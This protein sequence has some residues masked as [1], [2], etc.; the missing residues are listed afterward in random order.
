MRLLFS[1]L[2]LIFIPFNA[3]ALSGFCPKDSAVQIISRQFASIENVFPIRIGGVKIAGGVSLQRD[4]RIPYPPPSPVC[5]CWRTIAGIPVPLPGIIIGYYAPLATMEIVKMPGCFPTFSL[6]LPLPGNVGGDGSD[7]DAAS[8][9]YFEAHYIKFNVLELLNIFA[10][11]A[12]TFSPSSS[13]ID[14]GWITEYDPSWHDESISAFLTPETLLFANPVAQI[15]CSADSAANVIGYDIDV[16]YWCSGGASV[17][18]LSG[19]AGTTSFIRAASLDSAKML[20][21]MSRQG[22]LWDT[23]G[24]HMVSG[25]CMALPSPIWQ[26]SNFSQ[27]PIY[28]GFFPK[29]F[30]IGMTDAIWGSLINLPVP[31]K[32]GFFVFQIYQK[33]DCCAF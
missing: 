33:R 31:T 4:V 20:F 18:P 22:L 14:I 1:L 6:E 3:F 15:A 16:L 24:V 17:F 28:P 7:D 19:F 23:T 27:F 29:R 10:D 5:M 11:I 32:E 30:P 21:K 12:C 13:G 2:I 8:S 26:K 9:S 25:S